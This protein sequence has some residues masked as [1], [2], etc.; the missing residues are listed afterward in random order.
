MLG[1]LTPTIPVQIPTWRDDDVFEFASLFSL[2]YRL[3]AKKGVCHDDHTQSLTF[4]QAITEPVYADGVTSLLACVSNY[5]TAEGDGY[6]PS[7]LCMMGLA[8]QLHRSAASRAATT[9]PLVCWTQGTAPHGDTNGDDKY[10]PR[11][12]RMHDGGG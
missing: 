11:A 8:T 2:H 1:S 3:H 4:L 6:L 5:Y 12:L 10:H 9:I 7:L